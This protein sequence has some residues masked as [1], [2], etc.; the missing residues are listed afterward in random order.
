MSISFFMLKTYKILSFQIQPFFI[1]QDQSSS[2]DRRADPRQHRLVRLR[3]RLEPT[4]RSTKASSHSGSSADETDRV[5]RSRRTA[6]REDRVS[7]G[8]GIGARDL[9]DSGREP[10]GHGRAERI[11]PGEETLGLRRTRTR[12]DD[13]FLGHH[14]QLWSCR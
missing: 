3:L 6:R 14:Y 12:K 13:R 5:H 9:Q 1:F 11:G 7:T 10:M 8:E 4:R 2:R